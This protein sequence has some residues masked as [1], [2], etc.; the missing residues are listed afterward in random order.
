MG[1]DKNDKREETKGI[2]EDE[3]LIEQARKEK[4]T[5]E[6]R[7]RRAIEKEQGR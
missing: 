7:L 6:E 2:P 3:K 5:L 4:G 1:K